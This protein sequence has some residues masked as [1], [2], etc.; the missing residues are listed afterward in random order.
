MGSGRRKL[1]QALY[2]FIAEL[3]GLTDH[4]LREL[5][6]ETEEFTELNCTWMEYQTRTFVREIIRDRLG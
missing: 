4:Q 3:E 5:A 6:R 2:R 1:R